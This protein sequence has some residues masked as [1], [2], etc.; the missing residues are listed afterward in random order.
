[1]QVTG[2]KWLLFK[3]ICIYRYLCIFYPG[4]PVFIRI[5]SVPK[6]TANLYCICLSILHMQMQYRFAFNSGTLSIY[7]GN[8]RHDI[9]LA[10]DDMEL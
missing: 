8:K 6:V 1:M 9:Y 7:N 4:P 3:I 10:T 5:L 2:L